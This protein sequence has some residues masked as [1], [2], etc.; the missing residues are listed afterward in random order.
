VSRRCLVCRV[1]NAK[2]VNPDSGVCS[3]DIPY[4]LLGSDA[5]SSR[6]RVQQHRTA[7]VDERVA[8]YS[9]GCGAARRRR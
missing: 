5:A 1:Q 4:S 9:D 6:V 8:C 2:N 7:S 3:I